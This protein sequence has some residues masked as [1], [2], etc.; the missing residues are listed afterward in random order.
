MHFF[1]FFPV[2]RLHIAFTIVHFIQ[3][4]YTLTESTGIISDFLPSYLVLGHRE[5][6][7]TLSVVFNLSD[8]PLVAL[9]KDGFLQ[10]GEK[11]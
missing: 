9:Q 5:Q 10:R 11:H 7:V 2:N 4:V 6:Q 1:V 3:N 8:G